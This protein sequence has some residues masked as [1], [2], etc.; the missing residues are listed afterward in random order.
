MSHIKNM[1]PEKIQKAISDS[2]Y[3]QAG[4]A[5]DLHCSEAH[6]SRVIKGITPSHRVRSHIAKAVNIDVAVIWPETY[7]VKKD[8]TKKGRPLTSGLYDNNN[9]LYAA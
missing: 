6:I 9:D 8:P 4:L 5:R 1:P 2:G 7:L 3:S